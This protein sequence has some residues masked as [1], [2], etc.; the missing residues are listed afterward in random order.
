MNHRLDRTTQR[1]VHD[2][3]VKHYIREILDDVRKQ[4]PA[5]AR[6]RWRGLLELTHERRQPR[7]AAGAA[8]TAGGLHRPPAR[9]IEPGSSMAFLTNLAAVPHGATA[10]RRQH[11][12]VARPS[13][14]LRRA[15]VADGKLAAR[16]PANS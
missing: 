5:A 6:R 8:A 11:A 16:P 14:T 13:T 2:E 15:P 3:A 10:Q 1:G 9:F 7:P 12:G 4:G